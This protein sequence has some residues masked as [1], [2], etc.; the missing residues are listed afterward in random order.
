MGTTSLL[1][2][3]EREL[4]AQVELL[5]QR[6]DRRFFHWEAEFPEVFFGF[7]DSRHQQL[8]HK[9]RI[10]EGSAGF[11]CV[12]GNPP[13]DVLAEKELQTDLGD[14]LGYFKT[15]SGYAA[16]MGGKLNLYKLFICRNV[17]ITRNGG[18]VG[19]IVPMALLGDE[20]AVGVRKFLL[21]ET[22]LRAIEAFPQKDDAT[23][24]V[25][26]DAKLSTC[27]FVTAR[28]IDNGPFRCRVHPGKDIDERSPSQAIRRGDV[29]LYDPE[30]QPI[31]ACSQDDWDLATKIMG[32]GRLARLGDFC[33]AYQGEVNETTDAA[34][35]NISSSVKDGPQI[36]R[37]SNVCLYVL[38]EASQGET[39]YLR[40]AKFLKDKR[41]GA[42]AWHHQ[43]RRVG[44]QRKSPQNN[45][46]R[47][48]ACG[49]PLNEF[50]CDSVSYIPENDARLPLA[51]VHG[52]LNSRLLEWYFRLGST[53]ALVNEYQFN[54]LPAPRFADGEADVA[55]AEEFE[56]L[57]AVSDHAAAFA[58][59]EPL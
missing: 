58:L 37:G 46:R 14:L 28:V 47:L 41:P 23:N 48:I 25:F 49:I 12:V 36:L 27:V 38:R 45:F 30:N 55:L 11:D 35:G 54:I 8:R 43:Q 40:K 59:I 56:R 32:S 4:V 15:E 22:S 20:Q 5:A 13:Y 10:E 7:V 24:R 33:I 18:A 42:K 34:K 50:C 19:H 51:V 21:A 6:P 1:D 44:F 53:N 3:D 9:D 16:A 52:L 26:A 29:S 57:L 39:M 2:D 31:V 17:G